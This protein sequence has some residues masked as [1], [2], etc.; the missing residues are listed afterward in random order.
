MVCINGSALGGARRFG[1]K[2]WISV[3]AES[4]GFCKPSSLLL[5][6]NATKGQ[7]RAPFCLVSIERKT[8]PSTDHL[9]QEGRL[10]KMGSAAPPETDVL[11]VGAGFGG[12]YLLHLLRKNGFKVTLLEAGTML[13]GVVCIV[14]DKTGFW[15]DG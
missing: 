2:S 11:V 9:K 15:H 6:G 4:L 7:C 3:A 12:C 8:T 1:Q 13:G 10:L 14:W 5:R